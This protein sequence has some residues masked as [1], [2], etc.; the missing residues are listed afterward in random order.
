MP[1]KAP[2][3]ALKDGII[4]NAFPP[5]RSKYRHWLSRTWDAGG[6][7]ALVVGINPNEATEDTDDGMTRFL[8]RLLR[9]LDGDYTSG[10]FVLLNCCDLRNPKP[11]A[12]QKCPTPCSATNLATVRSK[13]A[14]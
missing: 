13:L 4:G 10:G 9:G 14:A 12:L 8:T 5:G 11:G 3:S 7:M 1:A 2:M 6:P